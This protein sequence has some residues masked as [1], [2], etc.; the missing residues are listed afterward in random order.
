MF[1]RHRRFLLVPLVT[2]LGLIADAANIIVDGVSVL[3]NRPYSSD[4]A[5]PN[6]PAYQSLEREFCDE[7]R[8]F[9]FD[10]KYMRFLTRFSYYTGLKRVQEKQ[11]LD[12]VHYME[13]IVKIT[14]VYKI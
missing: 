1:T 4:L 6:T 8:V 10:T 9:S 11:E 13:H 12:N 7:V 5:D 2:T 14:Q 3:E